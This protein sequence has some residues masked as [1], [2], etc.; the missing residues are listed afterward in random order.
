MAWIDV[1][2]RKTY[3]CWQDMKQRCTNPK[4]HNFKNYGA[5]GISVCDAWNS[6]DQFVLDMGMK[7]EGLTI[8]RIDNNKGYSP[9][10][11]RWATRAEQ[12]IN[13]RTCR[14]VVLNGERMPLRHA[15]AIVG[16]HETTLQQRMDYQGLS[17]EEAIS[18]PLRFPR[19]SVIRDTKEMQGMK[20]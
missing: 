11:C 6:F 19:S 14:Y 4:N 7:P 18:K 1:D 16:I 3:Q 10:N 12:R 15:A 9:E 20:K 5:R 17:F 8:D 13:Q 2:R